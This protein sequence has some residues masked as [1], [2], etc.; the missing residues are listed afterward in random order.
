METTSAP[1]ETP[2]LSESEQVKAEQTGN[3]EE[4]DYFEIA[5]ADT[6][7]DSDPMDESMEPSEP[8]KEHAPSEPEATPAEPVPEPEAVAAESSTEVPVVQEGQATE[9]APTE[10]PA[11]VE[12]PVEPAPEV[13]Y[14]VA[15]K[16]HQEKTIPRLEQL[17]TLSEDEA[18]EVNDLDAKP[19][20]WLPKYLAKMHYNVYMSNRAEQQATLPQ[21][22]SAI[23]QHNIESAKAEEQFFN[24]FPTLKDSR[25]LAFQTIQTVKTIN[26][27]LEGEE[28]MKAA[29]TAALASIGR[30]GQAVPPTAPAVPVVDPVVPPVPAAVG[31]PAAPVV[32]GKPA[33]Y[34]EGVYAA[35]LE[36]EHNFGT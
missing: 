24:L 7:G 6:E 2:E 11:A 18:A 15:L 30:L 8:V 34:E 20:D 28:L 22:V 14:Q 32:Q 36:E 23:S 33:S 29:G 9:P 1:E 13:D 21:V 19:S 4:P 5:T 25:D 16:E 31:S 10:A 12:T 26:P 27:A 3:F 17:Y 35:I